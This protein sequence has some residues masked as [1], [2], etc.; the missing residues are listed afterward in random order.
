MRFLIGLFL[1]VEALYLIPTLAAQEA[2]VHCPD[3]RCE[4]GIRKT[5]Q[6]EPLEISAAKRAGCAIASHYSARLNG[7]PTAS[8]ARYN[9]GGISVAHRTLPFGTRVKITNPSNGRSVVVQVNDRG[10]FVAGR[11]WDLSG[12]AKSA[13]GGGGLTCVQAE[14]LGRGKR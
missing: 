12:G 2:V 10:P 5:N 9:H 13:I 6:L 14:V 1:V 8:G 4:S 3:G 11:V 7:R